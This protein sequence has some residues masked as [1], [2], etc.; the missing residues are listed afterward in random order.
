[1]L[2]GKVLIVR[3]NDGELFTGRK[4]RSK[5]FTRNL[6]SIL[7]PISTLEKLQKKRSNLGKD[8]ETPEN[9]DWIQVW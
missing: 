6:R 3:N 5:N 7:N 4:F 8:L 9:A 1:M 2:M